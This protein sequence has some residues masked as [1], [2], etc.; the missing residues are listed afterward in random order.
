MSRPIGLVFCYFSFGSFG[1]NLRTSSYKSNNVRKEKPTNNPRAP[2]NSAMKDVHPY[3]FL[4]YMR[5]AFESDRDIL[6][7]LMPFSSSFSLSPAN[8][9]SVYLQ[10]FRHLVVLCKVVG[11]ISAR[12]F[13][14]LLRMLN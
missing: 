6:T 10:G 2:P 7:S 5:V 12:I 3:N 13:T 1:M 9:Y 8:L 4:S 11:L 14:S